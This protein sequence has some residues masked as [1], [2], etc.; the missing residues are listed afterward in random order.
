MRFTGGIIMG[1]NVVK[2]MSS[3]VLDFQDIDKTKLMVVGVKARTWGNFPRLKEY[4]YRMAFVS[5]LMPL[6]ELL[7]KP[8]RLT[9]YLL[10]YRF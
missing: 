4:A 9:N 5:L 6:K 8:R 10:S 3:F 2:I 1:K 7:G